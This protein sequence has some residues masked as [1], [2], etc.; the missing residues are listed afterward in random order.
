M[1]GAING[2]LKPDWA[3]LLIALYNNKMDIY[4]SG[5][6]GR[7]WC[8]YD[9]MKIYMAGTMDGNQS[10][11]I[12]K[13]YKNLMGCDENKI[14]LAILESFAYA[15]EYIEKAI[16]LISDFLLDSGAY[17]YMAGKDGSEVNWEE[18]IE[19]YANFINKNKVER[20]IEL[21][22][23]SLVGYDEVKRLRKLLESKTNKQPI[24][25][26]HKSRGKDEFLKMCDEYPY[27]AI[28]G[29]VT[30][31]IKRTEYKVFPWFINEAHKR[32]AKIHGLGL[33]N[34][35]AI[36]KY[37]FDSVDSSSWTAGNRFGHISK[38]TGND[39][40][41]YTKPEG[42][43]LKDSREVAENN[44]NEWVKFQRWAKNNL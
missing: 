25:V 7:R 20:F 41:Y 11:F 33:T 38:F 17:T 39:I 1:A 16:P 10:H 35:E 28:G 26:W 23:D 37:H 8:I 34:I 40:V 14:D 27:V 24:V 31:E 42:T 21:D 9:Y 30:K 5:T 15:D 19:R 3:K 18:Y 36:K 12:K 4:L 22:I 2:N 32:D 44:F 43:R 6:N 29:L 13:H